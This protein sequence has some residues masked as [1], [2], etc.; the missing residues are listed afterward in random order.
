MGELYRELFERLVG[1]LLSD[2]LIVQPTLVRPDSTEILI[3]DRCIL[4]LSRSLFSFEIGTVFVCQWNNIFGK[5]VF[6]YFCNYYYLFFNLY[7][8]DG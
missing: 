3:S 7:F 8:L 2:L 4:G 6:S 5:F 1:P